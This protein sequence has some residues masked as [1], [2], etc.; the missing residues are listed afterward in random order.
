MACT[1]FFGA[2]HHVKSRA[3]LFGQSRQWGHVV[4]ATDIAFCR[5]YEDAE[6]VMFIRAHNLMRSSEGRRVCIGLA[7]TKRTLDIIPQQRSTVARVS[8]VAICLRCSSVFCSGLHTET[9]CQRMIL[10]VVMFCCETS[11]TRRHTRVRKDDVYS[12]STSKVRSDGPHFRV[13]SLIVLQQNW[14]ACRLN[15]DGEK[16]VVVPMDGA[17]RRKTGISSH[18]YIACAP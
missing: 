11:T 4:R 12:K 5:D 3:R 18:A 17:H 8:W 9:C 10:S 14:A 15:A 7:G 16:A 6:N 2:Q 13:L 1:I